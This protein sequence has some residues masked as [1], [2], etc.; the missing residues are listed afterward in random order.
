MGTEI[1]LQ[2]LDLPDSCIVQKTIYKKYFYDNAGLRSL[3]KKLF[4]SNIEKV[5]W[6]Y[7]LKPQTINIRPYTDDEY[8]FLEI[9]IIEAELKEKNRY[10][11]IAEIIMRSIPYPII[12][13]LTYEKE[14]MV[15]AGIPRK[16][17]ADSQ[18]LTIEEFIYSPWIK[19]ADIEVQD[20]KFFKNIHS[21]NISFTNLFRFYLDF[22]DQL[23]LYNAAKLLGRELKEDDPLKAKQLFLEIKKLQDDLRLLRSDLKKE[24]MFHRKIELNL[25]IKELEQKIKALLNELGR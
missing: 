10:Q 3:D 20:K 13:Q 17:L 9:Q 21:S 5:T 25:Q 1:F 11:R 8:E 15:V 4:T 7:C 16:N 23:H 18:R 22:V 2:S 19:S 12:L 6:Q 14:L 24:T